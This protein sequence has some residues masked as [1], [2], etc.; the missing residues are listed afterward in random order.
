MTFRPVLSHLKPYEPGRPVAGGIKLSSN[1]NPLGPSPLALE[2]IGGALADLSRYPESSLLTLRSAIAAR[3][4]VEPEMVVAGNGSDEIMAMI[5]GALIEPGTNA[6]TGAN[7]F[8]Q[9]AFVTRIFGGEVRTTEMPDGRFVL[10]D[11]LARVDADTRIVWLCSP[12]NPTGTLITDD[13]LVRFIASVPPTVLIVIDE[14]YGEYVRAPNYPDTLALLRS[15]P[16]LIRLRT[17]SKI[18]GLAALRIGY[19][20]AQAQTIREIGKLRQPFNVGTVSQVAAIAALGDHA[21]VERSLAI[22]EAQIARIAE[23]L[24]QRGIRCHPSDA[25]FV[26][27]RFPGRARA[28]VDEALARGVSLRWLG[29]FDMPDWIRI[30]VGTAIEVDELFRVLDLVLDDRGV[31]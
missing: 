14:A 30:S 16:N 25:N 7:T 3:W 18:Y 9:Y 2:A 5:A 12:N 28:I 6:V 26:C 29:S 11:V 15:Y 8:S 17:F 22:N 21:F 27:A 13:E 31:S 24:E 20:I 10:D 19:G 1:E 23:W 4:A